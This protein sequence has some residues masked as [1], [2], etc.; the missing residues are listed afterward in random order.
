MI[1]DRNDLPG[2]QSSITKVVKRFRSFG[3]AE[4]LDVFRDRLDM[5]TGLRWICV[6]IV[7]TLAT[8][9]MTKSASAQ[10]LFERR[11][12]NQVDQYRN[13]A[14]RSRGDLL[15]ILIN[16]ST[17]VENRDETSLDKSGSSTANAGVDYGLGSD[18]GNAT[19][20]GD[21]GK[22]SSSSRAFSGDSEFRSARQFS[23]KFTVTIVD[24]LPNGNLV[25]QGER[26]ISVQGD[27]RHLRLS[28]IVRQF[29]VLPNNSVPSYMVANLKIELD[30]QGA[31]QSFTKQGWFSRRV[32]RLW[33]F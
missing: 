12:V 32:N 19:G 4:N 30:A 9:G 10:S 20:N 11:S 22:T 29:D 17:D 7:A 14:A 1:D 21:F 24:V 3:I 15:S 6:L 33:P 13:Y 26:A 16:E 18:L 23:D 8:Q 2:E 5:K 31:E 25:V 27:E 28:G